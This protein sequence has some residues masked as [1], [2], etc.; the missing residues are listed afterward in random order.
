MRPHSL[1]ACALLLL[2]SSPYAAPAEQ[3]PG[4]KVPTFGAGVTLASLP[5]FVTDEQGKA[6]AGLTAADFVVE[7]DGKPATIVGF[8]AFDANDPEMAEKVQDAPAA[9]RQF[10]L[11]FDASF[12]GIQGLSRAREAGLD[13]LANRLAPSDLVAVAI[14]SNLY[15]MRTLVNFTA[16]RNQARRAVNT[17]GTLA[18]D[19]RADPLGLTYDLRDL[20]SLLSDTVRAERGPGSEDGRQLMVL[21]QRGERIGYGDQVLNFVAALGNLAQGLGA[22][23]GR[24]QVILFS[25]GFDEQTLVGNQGK[26]AAQDSEAT[27]RGRVW[28]VTSDDRFGDSNVRWQM[29]EALK[30][31]ARA[32]AV[33]H[34]VDLGGLRA[35]GDLTQQTTET[36]RPVGG[37]ESL[38]R[39]AN[40]TGG[41][42]F[43]DTND[44][45]VA[46]DEVLEMSRYYYLIAFEP[47]SLSK[48][49][50]Y[51]KLKVRV[52]RKDA[53]VAYRSG[54]FERQPYEAM[55]P[56]AREFEAAEI[57]AKGVDRGELAVAAQALPYRAA[58]NAPLLSVVLDVDSKSLFGDRKDKA[59]S[60]EIYGY[61]LDPQGSVVDTI[62]MVANL[63]IAQLESRLRNA[64][65]CQLMFT[66]PAGKYDLRF[67][68][69]D[70]QSGRSGTAWL[71]V[72]MPSFET[73][74]LSLLP[75]MVMAGT[76]DRLILHARSQATT[77]QASPFVVAKE[78]FAPQNNPRFANGRKERLCLLAYD[79]GR[80][81]DPGAAF[82]IVPEFVDASGTVLPATTVDIVRSFAANGYRWFVLDL[83]PNG[84]APGEYTLRARVRDADSG[85]TSESFRMV[86]IE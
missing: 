72:T 59:R 28:E 86:R 63:D 74:G 49:G 66:L 57:I 18:Q 24:K 79:G 41:R 3:A 65:Q 85:R 8:S 77:S 62:G 52:N 56:L 68:V 15:G 17:L 69:R 23:Q 26:T 12:T 25:S 30:S 9:R 78:A 33:V 46:L 47:T 21:Y 51:H 70:G 13:F 84:V 5:V 14:Y 50:R 37:R 73:A 36:Q 40:I 58:A 31:F 32:D 45:K 82:E 44:P 76:D 10:L 11:L 42:L 6:L 2:V 67:L 7:D 27:L 55:T 22:V 38:A 60:L 43:K 20:G 54:Y 61:A 81:Y 16:D 64:V 71:Q 34:P 48:P 4:D 80:G 75:P 39:I 29:E 35:R 83:T 19:R 1:R 53:R